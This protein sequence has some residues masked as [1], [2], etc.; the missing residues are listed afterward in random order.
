MNAN[1]D[2]SKERR[3]TPLP[4]LS[5]KRLLL[6][7]DSPANARL[8]IAMLKLH[9][10]A[11]DWR[12]NGQ[13]GLDALMATPD[14]YDAVLVDI[15]MPGMD[16]Y[17]VV[18]R[19]RRLPMLAGLPAMAVTA[20]AFPEDKERAFAA[21]FDMFLA[22]P[23]TSADL[24]RSLRSLFELA[25]VRRSPGADERFPNAH[26]KGNDPIAADVDCIRF[27]A[28]DSARALELIDG[29]LSWL[30]NCGNI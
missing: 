5:G 13:A 8:V 20:N 12:D 25:S 11:V 15:Q 14:G 30:M 17:E 6:V 27:A 16:G 22:K 7:E 18:R 10:V 21:G 4:A 19:M 24:A 23:F 2:N 26:G 1:D 9:D 3:V 28:F 29:I